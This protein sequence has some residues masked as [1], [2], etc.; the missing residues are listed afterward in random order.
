MPTYLPIYPPPPLRPVMQVEKEDIPEVILAK[1]KLCESLEENSQAVLY[2]LLARCKK[3]RNSAFVNGCVRAGVHKYV[4]DCVS[5]V[6]ATKESVMF[7]LCGDILVALLKKSDVLTALDTTPPVKS[8]DLASI[9]GHAAE[10]ADLRAFVD[11]LVLF[12]QNQLRKVKQLSAGT[13]I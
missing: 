10:K 12:L 9:A 8:I 13:L 2:S 11:A 3:S 6:S 1:L 5:G 4:L 7:A